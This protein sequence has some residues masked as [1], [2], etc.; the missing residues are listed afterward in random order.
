MFAFELGQERKLTNILRIALISGAEYCHRMVEVT[1][2][3]F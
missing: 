1:A 3:K 2:G